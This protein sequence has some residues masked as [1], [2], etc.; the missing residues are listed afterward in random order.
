MRFRAS[1]RPGLDRAAGRTPLAVGLY[2]YA[3]PAGG[4]IVCGPQTARAV[5]YNTEARTVLEAGAGLVRPAS[6]PRARTRSSRANS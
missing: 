2:R 4:P 1:R 3:M 5:V 6:W